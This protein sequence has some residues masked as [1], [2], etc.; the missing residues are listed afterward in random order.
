MKVTISVKIL[1][2]LFLLPSSLFAQKYSKEERLDGSE[3]ELME[4]EGWKTCDP[5]KN[6]CD[7][8]QTLRILENA[9]MDQ[10]DKTSARRYQLSTASFEHRSLNTARL[11]AM[12]KAKKE[13]AT[14]ME[15][16][17]DVTSAKRQKTGTEVSDS[18][19]SA[20]NKNTDI[21]LNDV[22]EILAIYRRKNSNL[23]EVRVLT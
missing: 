8:F 21:D 3:W 19:G 16:T 4:N 17:I 13:L 14:S 2:I 10:E 22:E 11:L 9:P 12:T 1:L 18:H 20:I 15:T 5:Q 6:L 23:Y 7:G